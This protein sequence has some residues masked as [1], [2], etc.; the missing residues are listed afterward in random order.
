MS[1]IDDLPEWEDSITLGVG[2]GGVRWF[3]EVCG[4]R[5]AWACQIIV[6]MILNPESLVNG[7]EPEIG[8][9][10]NI[11]ID[12]ITTIFKTRWV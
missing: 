9:M 8:G 7:I 6:G 1:K 4:R 2:A 5:S 3:D 10:R 11:E 12:D